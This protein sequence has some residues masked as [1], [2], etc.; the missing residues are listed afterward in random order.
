MRGGEGGYLGGRTASQRTRRRS[1]TARECWD[2]ESGE[3]KGPRASREHGRGPGLL[4]SSH[5]FASLRQQATRHAA[6]IPLRGSGC[7]ILNL[8]LQT[9]TPVPI[10]PRPCHRKLAATQ[11]PFPWAQVVMVFLVFLALL[12]PFVVTSFVNEMVRGACVLATVAAC[13]SA[14]TV[15]VP[16][17]SAHYACPLP[18]LLPPTQWMGAVRT[19]K[20]LAPPRPPSSSLFSCSCPV[21]H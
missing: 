3:V 13:V 14:V 4:L 11:F 20:P 15:T 8:L 5:H 9:C 12:L 1:A 7:G 21:A 6:P 17:Q 18:H 10:F 19:F 16:L 2:P